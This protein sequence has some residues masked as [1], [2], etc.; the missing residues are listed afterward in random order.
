MSIELVL[1]DQE[2]RN[3]ITS[4]LDRTMFVEAGAG[5]GKTRAIVDRV[6]QL[7]LSGV[8]LDQIAAITFTE[9]AAA[10]LRT[11][12]RAAL[13]SERRSGPNT[14]V[15]DALSLIETA[16]ITTLHG[17]ALRILTDYPIEAGLPPGFTVADEVS[18]IVAF[19]N[20]WRS[21][22]A[23][24]GDDLG[25]FQ[26]QARASVLGIKL[27]RFHQV[28]RQFDDNWDLLDSLPRHQRDQGWSPDDQIDSSGV[29]SRVPLDSAVELHPLEF[30]PVFEA[31][32]S[33][34]ARTAECADETDAMVG[35]LDQ[36]VHEAEQISRLDGLD[37]LQWLA[38]GPISKAKRGRKENWPD[39]ESVREELAAVAGLMANEVDHVRQEI[40]LNYRGLVGDFVRERVA[41]RRQ[42]GELSF[43]D[44][45][46][47]ARR[48]MRDDETV[49]DRLHQ[50]YRRILLDEFQDTDPIQIELAVLLASGDPVGNTPWTE[51]AQRLPAGSLV[52]VGD[53][54]QSIYRFRRADI[55][56]YAASEENLVDEPVR[57]TTNF[58]SVPGIV[59]FVNEVFGRVIGEGKPGVQPAYVALT[60]R[61]EALESLAGPPDSADDAPVRSPVVLLGGPHKDLAVGEIRRQEAEDIAALICQF[62]ADGRPVWDEDNGG[63]RPVRL[64]D[65][66]ILIPS[67]LSL[68]ALESALSEVGLPVRPETSSLVYATQE[69]RDVLAGVR[70]VANPGEVLDVVAALRSWLFAV[71]DAELFSWSEA[72]GTWDYRQ[73]PPA[74]IPADHPVVE[75]FA[76]LHR[77]H[78]D[79][80]WV[81]PAALVDRIVRERALREQ[82]LV[83]DRSRDRWRRYRFL[84][85][86]ARGFGAGAAGDL[87]DF[88][89]WA[90]LQASD[91]ARVTEPIPAEPD[92]DAIRLLTIH[93]AKGLEFPVTILAGAPTFENNRS[94]GPSVLFR[95]GRPPEVQLNRENAT[96]DYAAEASTEDVLDTHERIRL[97]YVAATRAR[98]WLVVSAHHKANSKS[99][100]RRTYEAVEAAAESG[101]DDLVERFERQGDERYEV[102]SPTQLSLSSG[103]YLEEFEEWKRAQRAFIDKARRTGRVSAT[104]LAS[105]S[106]EELEVTASASRSSEEFEVTASSPPGRRVRSVPARVESEDPVPKPSL[107]TAIGT[108]VHAVLEDVDLATGSD[109]EQLARHHAQLQGIGAESD[110]VSVLARSA[111]EAPLVRQAA[112]GR[113]WRELPLAVPTPA[114]G[115]FEGIVDLVIES[116]DGLVVVDYKTDPVRDQDHAETLRAAYRLQLGSYA[117]ALE[118]VADQPVAAAYLLFVASDGAIE[119][120]IDDLADA[121]AEVSGALIATA[122]DPAR[123]NDEA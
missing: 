43:H 23:S 37:Q 104:A 30:T 19:D 98:D 100:G 92:D 94:S 32:R 70:A 79:R 71:T 81:K 18:S 6:V 119:L 42:S 22:L 11:R 73:D 69:V 8:R 97:H 41:A 10:E 87:H 51:L 59:R 90:E 52:V 84:A 114:G 95:E 64:A 34:G 45:L 105:R 113:H 63:W 91:V 50:R 16:P 48:L 13:D 2:A 99:I 75:A 78:Q 14:R 96:A 118:A 111:W 109:L 36:L 72:G 40:L 24:V 3:A 58:R 61:R 9:A 1:E 4:H 35:A 47:L 108:A 68:P 7:V 17:F 93:G 76:A 83:A 106:S 26:L 110:R 82:T 66:A 53:P 67:R 123:E 55:G 117:W 44:L 112:S 54:K 39:I 116:D 46:V 28:A 86:Q 122:D 77:W 15:D 60:A 103:E 29:A 33:L 12:I 56:V 115:L 89:E 101:I 74:T 20:A 25:L 38:S 49:R 80:W 5:S 62:M 21:F 27:S 120:P 85:E 102:V 57:L 121:V 31:I 65:I 88:I 107:G